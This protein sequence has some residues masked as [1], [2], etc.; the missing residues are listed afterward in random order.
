LLVHCTMNVTG[1]KNYSGH[2]T[3]SE[4]I[5]AFMCVCVH[6]VVLP[7]ASDPF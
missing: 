4:M 1:H 7:W 6:A 2:C 5:F 3:T